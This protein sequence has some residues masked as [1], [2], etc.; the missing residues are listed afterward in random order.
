MYI[1]FYFILF[2]FYGLQKFI[3]SVTILLNGIRNVSDT[4]TTEKKI[5]IKN[6]IK[7]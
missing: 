1:N 4:P 5:Q 2:H 3:K 7:Q 6:K